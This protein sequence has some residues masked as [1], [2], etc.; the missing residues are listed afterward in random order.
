M[1]LRGVELVAIVITA[2]LLVTEVIV[3]LWRGVPL[4]PLLRK[5]QRALTSEQAAAKQDAEN[6]RAEERIA[7]EKARADS[8][9]K[10]GRGI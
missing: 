8:I 1:F 7:R 9:R 6:A 10:K 2:A 3:P 5:R 4:L